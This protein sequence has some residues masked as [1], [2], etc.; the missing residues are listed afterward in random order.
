MTT[1]RFL[2]HDWFPEPLP[3]NV[4]IGEG[5]WCYSSF[6]FFHSQSRRARAV[7]IGNH[8][9]IYN[10]TFFELGEEGEVE[11]GDYCTLVAVI[12]A[13][14]SRVMIGDYAFLAHNV[15]LADSFAAMPHAIDRAK[16]RDAA[17]IIE[18]NAWIGA[19][20]ILLGGA[21]IG[22]GSIVGAAA[23]VDFRVPPYSIVAGNTASVVG[24]VARA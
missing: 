16:D 18:S 22:E 19:R 8:S 1:S 4:E 21:H 7:T 9:G 14:N 23:V 24:K 3:P 6:A 15:V 17:I 13:T 5:S 20:A 11:I 2:D 12:I 10:P